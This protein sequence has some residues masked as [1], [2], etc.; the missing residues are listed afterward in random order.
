M[1]LAVCILCLGIFNPVILVDRSYT[2]S[3]FGILQ[4]SSRKT[5]QTV[6]FKPKTQYKNWTLNVIYFVHGIKYVIAAIYT[7]IYHI[8]FLKYKQTKHVHA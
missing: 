8:D 3:V 2:E 1:R 7:Y 5:E 4:E 6:Q